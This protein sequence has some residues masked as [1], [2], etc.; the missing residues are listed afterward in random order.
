MQ[1]LRYQPSDAVNFRRSGIANRP[2]TFATRQTQERT[3]S[4]EPSPVGPSSGSPEALNQ[5]PLASW[6]VES[7]EGFTLLQRLALAHLI[8]GVSVALALGWQI[9]SE[10]GSAVTPAIGLI[11]AIGGTLALLLSRLDHPALHVWARLALIAVDLAA[12]SGI[13]WV[14]GTEGWT[15]LV[16]LPPIALA[17]AFFAERGGALATM[18]ATLIIGTVSY[19]RDMATS[20]WMP[21]LLVFLGVAVLIV[22]FLGIY[23]AKVAA[24]CDHLRGLLADAQSASERSHRDR[25]KLV[26]RLRSLEQAYEP[27][28]HEHVRLGEAAAELTGLAQRIGQGDQSAAQAL[29]SVRPGAYGPLADLTMAMV[30]WS[31]VPAGSWSPP[32]MS[33]LEYP[34]RAQGQALESLDQMARSLCAGANELVVEAE[35]LEPGI[36][37][38]GSR[39]YSAALW[40]LEERLR[41]QASHVALFGTHLA[42]IRNSQENV[43]AVLTQ[44]AAGAKTPTIFA[45]SDVRSSDRIGERSD[46]RTARHFSGPQA[47]LGASAIRPAAST[48]N[49]Y[50]TDR[51]GHWPNEESVAY[52]RGV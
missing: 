28:L 51:W 12:T 25:Q 4:R 5:L 21:S 46:I 31:R 44:R 19:S 6:W 9:W 41:V 34:V 37:L 14:R 22:A 38:I 16:L 26:A 40:Q 50:G 8:V 1:Q 43:E 15:L 30:R 42:D 36:S 3:G 18:L 49:D 29:Q 35:F 17:V 47:T 7:D 48:R 52:N 23:S 20:E 13:L 2:D 39:L 10:S 45:T 27:L 24:T 32:T 11:V 33:A